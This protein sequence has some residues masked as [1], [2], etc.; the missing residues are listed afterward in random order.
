LWRTARSHFVL[1]EFLGVFFERL[2]ALGGS[3]IEEHRDIVLGGPIPK[4]TDQGR[5]ALLGVA[6]VVLFLAKENDFHGFFGR[7]EHDA[8]EGELHEIRFVDFFE[9]FQ[10]A[11]G[12]RLSGPADFVL[13]G[14]VQQQIMLA[15]RELHRRKWYR[16]A[17]FLLGLVPLS[18]GFFDPLACFEQSQHG[19]MLGLDFISCVAALF[20]LIEQAASDGESGGLDVSFKGW[21]L[22]GLVPKP[23][24]LFGLG[25]SFDD[26]SRVMAEGQDTQGRV[27]VL[28]GSVSDSFG[29]TL[30]QYGDLGSRQ[31]VQDKVRAA[32][33]QDTQE[34]SPS[35]AKES[36]CLKGGKVNHRPWPYA[37]TKERK[38]SW[39]VVGVPIH[40]HRRR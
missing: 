33:W 31:T 24:I 27:G 13:A 34:Q 11:L 35:R 17:K 28:E 1:L 14:V 40:R 38:L 26:Q 5:V 2:H 37:Q 10:S 12:T 23:S 16:L 30:E 36:R 20:E 18:E 39:V 29:F 9:Q 4:G 19:R 21:V 3:L 15:L 25:G 8:F 22:A 32:C 6:D 7:I